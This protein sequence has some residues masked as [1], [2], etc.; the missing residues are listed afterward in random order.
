M[1][2]YSLVSLLFFQTAFAQ[3]P[4]ADFNVALDEELRYLKAEAEANN[5]IS[6][7]SRI[8]TQQKDAS[9]ILTVVTEKE[10]L[11]SGARDLI[12]VL[13][14]VPGFDFGTHLSNVNG[15][16]LRG[17]WAEEGGL[18]LMIDGLEM[19]DRMNG[20]VQLGQHYP[21]DNIQ[22]IE[23]MRGPGSVMYGGFARLGVINIITKGF[24]NSNFYQH[25]KQRTLEKEKDEA[26]ITARYGE[27]EKTYGH[28]G[29]SFYAGKNLTDEAR[30]TVSAK[31]SQGNRSDRTYMNPSTGESIPLANVNKMEG[32]LLNVGFQYGN[33][34]IMR[35]IYDDY[36]N[37]TADVGQLTH[38]PPSIF[39]FKSHQFDAKYKHDFT[40][41]LKLSFNFNYSQ[42]TPWEYDEFIGNS[43]VGFNYMTSTRYK[44]SVRA[45]YAVNNSI[46]ITNGFE[47]SH[48]E[49]EET[50][51]KYSYYGSTPDVLPIYENITPYI[52]GLL[53]TDWG[54][55]TL[56][57]RYDKHNKF[58]SNLAPRAAFTGNLGDFH[59]KLLYSDS[60]RTP[61]IYTQIYSGML[62][63]KPERTKA[64]EV[65]LGYQVNNNLSLSTNAYYLSTKDKLVYGYDTDLSKYVPGGGGVTNLY[66]NARDKIQSVGVETELRW[67]QDW[68]YVT[69]NHS[70][71][72]ML[73]NF[74]DYQPI[75]QI[76]GQVVN[77]DLALSFPAHKLTLN[78]HY[79]ITPA[80]SVNPSLILTS[81][82]YGY[83][84]FDA[85]G[86]LTLRK[87]SPEVL[88][89]L[90]FRYQNVLFKGLELGVG[91]YNIFNS[92]QRFVQPYNS[93]HPPL[94]GQSREFIFKISYQ[95]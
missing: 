71:T 17:N 3:T 74:K 51:Q 88:G 63:L 41:D 75:N 54:N 72:Q 23:V 67:K 66:Y 44:G 13:R 58:E 94:P 89:N 5:Y 32:L 90:Y 87:Y 70:Y 64:Y 4:P 28:R 68:G 83:D 30:L 69:F 65:E 81:S 84:T 53:K 22:R 26:A 47:F 39:S 19:N 7:A 6:I 36:V 62:I 56:G 16:M 76:T 57:L 21:I 20:T 34:L 27:M 35:F 31:A 37:W 73:N 2:R 85:N 95:L 9:G 77:S 8:P 78:G 55:L 10:I 50:K 25:Q 43:Y 11:N 92:N 29:I 24:K 60:F 48:E 42:Q 86:N 14:L 40:K 18:L 79:K 45:D 59:Y 49:F 91:A 80:F 33:D 61:T 38:L 82:R 46:H 1:K 15:P 52:E 93:A 12:D